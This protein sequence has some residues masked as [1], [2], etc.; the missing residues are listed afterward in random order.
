GVDQL[1]RWLARLALT[2]DAELGLVLAGGYAMSA[3]A[4]TSRPSQYLDF[5][6]RSPLP[7]AEVAGRLA[8]VLREAGC[9]VTVV[10][11]APLMARMEVVT[12]GQVCE[13]DLLKGLSGRQCCWRW[14]R[15]WL[16]MMPSG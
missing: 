9:G 15:C 11:V 12:D 16:W 13:I 4:L 1:H 8:E 3:H 10:D 2:A 5:A 14:D 6:T 7:M